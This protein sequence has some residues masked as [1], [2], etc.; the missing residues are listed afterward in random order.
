MSPQFALSWSCEVS[1]HPY[2][3]V[4]I[5]NY[6]CFSLMET[7]RLACGQVK[8]LLAGALF[9]VKLTDVEPFVRS[10]TVRWVTRP[11]LSERG[12]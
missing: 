12:R 7:C 10:V 8:F 2:Y 3:W 9:F 1:L 4:P 6:L 5:T 11:C